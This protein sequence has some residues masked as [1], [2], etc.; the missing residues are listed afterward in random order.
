LFDLSPRFC[1]AKKKRGACEGSCSEDNGE[2]NAGVTSLAEFV[3]FQLSGVVVS[4][5]AAESI[6][7]SELQK[8]EILYV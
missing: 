4:S 1:G 6:L 2:C 7:T 8:W 5:L 3:V